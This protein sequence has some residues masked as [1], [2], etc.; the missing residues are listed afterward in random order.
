MNEVALQVAETPFEE[1]VVRI[2]LA[3]ALG[4]FLGL[5]R[6]WSQKSAGIRTF[7]LISLLA[8]VF[9]VLAIETESAIG[10]GLLVLGG[11]LVIVQGVLLAVQGLM[12]EDETGLSLTT[13]VSMLVAYGVGALVAVGF[14]LEGVTVAV[15]SSLLLVLKRELHEFAWGL[16]HE[17]MRSTIEFAILAFVIYPI[18]PAE[19]TVEFA[20]LAIPLEPQ[21][22]WL[23]VVAVAGIGIANYAIVTTYGGRGIAITGFFGGLAS[24]TAVVG[25]MLD[26][27]RQRPE[28]ASYAVAAI[29]LANAAMAT[30]NL[31]IAVGFTAGSDSEIL[32]EAIVPLGAVIVLAFAVAAL[33]ADWDE[34]G[35]MELE[36]P[37]SLRN[38]L[39]FGVVFLG[40]LVF[41][42]LAET[43]FGTLGFYA[44]AVASGFVSSAGA[45]TS[46]VVLYRGGQLG[47]PEATVAILL[48]TVS[49]IVVKALL[50]STSTNTDFR[51]R[52]TAYSAILLIGGTLAS[53]LVV[54]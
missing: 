46:A 3:G 8:A 5:E 38:A 32:V 42:S 17:E 45:T 4:M 31:A 50:A 1:T 12:S 16:S 34:S 36:S 21:V 22:I 48:A 29:L 23:M 24:S 35:P 54:V 37:F 25:T 33:T 6:E 7:S 47:G 13:S 9:T 49:S 30:R 39:G 11:V 2:A 19:T 20:G 10:E 52:V 18:L 27:V 26:H 44:T 40:V 28:A 41:G 53:V 51:N 14:I 15:L 43:W